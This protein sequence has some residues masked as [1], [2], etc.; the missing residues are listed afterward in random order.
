[1][2]PSEITQLPPLTAEQVE[3]IEGVLGKLTARTWDRTSREEVEQVVRSLALE[4]A[5]PTTK[6]P[7]LQ[8]TRLRFTGQK[9]L[10]GQAPQPFEYNQAFASGVN[11]IC[12]P[13]NDV[14]KSSILKTIKFAL[15]CD[16]DYDND[17]KS[18]ISDI[19]LTFRLNQQLFT[20]V[21]ALRDG[22]RAALVA[23]EEARPL[24]D[25]VEDGATLLEGDSSEEVRVKLQEFFFRRLGLEKLSWTHSDARNPLPVERSVSWRTYFQA[26]YIPDNADEYLL[27]DDKHATGNQGGLILSA[28]LGLSL[29]RPLN[30][31]GVEMSL[32]R[33]EL[34]AAQQA[35]EASV[36]AAQAEMAEL[37]DRIAEV[38]R[39]LNKLS[40]TQA[41][42][43][44]A[45]LD[46]KAGTR[47]P[48]ALAQQAAEQRLIHELEEERQAIGRGLRAQR[49]RL[50]RLKEA[51]ALRMHFTGLEVELCPSCDHG[52]DADAIAREQETHTCRLCGKPAQQADGDEVE[53]FRQEAVLITQN[54]R[55]YEQGRRE[56]AQ[57]LEERQQVS[58]QLTAEVTLLQQ[59][60]SQA[61][62]DVL[63]TPEEQA[64]TE[65]F[66]LQLGQLTA[67]FNDAKRRANPPKDREEV[68]DRA[69]FTRGRV[70][71]YL[72]AEAETRNQSLLSQLSQLTQEAARTIGA[73]SFSDVTCSALG[74]V[75][76]KKHGEP[77]KFTTIRNQGERLRIKLA[78]FLAMM[79][80]GRQM[81]AGRHPGFLIIDQP[82][83][84]EMV[85]ED[86]LALAGIFHELDQS[87][88][89]ELQII[90]ATARPEFS[91][92]TAPEKVYGPSASG[93]AF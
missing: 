63:P 39:A 17:V 8:V 62:D 60:A 24:Q 47:L 79:R 52:V 13:D 80:L 44:K 87:N 88:G 46:P 53:E 55:E 42:R 1:M 4:E 50:K 75:A 86:F 41:Q 83:S 25:V 28:L 70:R 67:A 54:I 45:L 90:T 27:V 10:D 85:A 49:A 84:G 36:T 2:K 7:V 20:V 6:A 76:L 33:K 56:L 29:T 21:H 48:Q 19:W 12:V 58:A 37:T 43:R 68:L 71:E 11:V 77:V 35:G 66:Y 22:H 72:Q 34:A 40:D 3:I 78:F 5:R 26:L 16:D 31:L 92:A 82:G 57:R 73:E 69:A 81:G 91:V 15:T 38:R 65:A 14:G 9:H 51:I 74:T 30:R 59:V 89:G 64:Q 61:L 18:W 32:A 23:Q 93:H